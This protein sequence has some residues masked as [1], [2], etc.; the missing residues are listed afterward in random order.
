MLADALCVVGKENRLRVGKRRP[1][2]K[3]KQSAAAAHEAVAEEAEAE[4]Q[5]AEADAEE[6]EEV[7][8]GA[9]EE[10]TQELS[11]AD[12]DT[13]AQ[14]TATSQ[15]ARTAD[16]VHD[17]AGAGCGGVHRTGFHAVSAD[18]TEQG[19]LELLT[20][21]TA[22]FERHTPASVRRE[23]SDPKKYATNPEGLQVPGPR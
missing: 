23:E 20:R 7:G 21:L 12:D 2:R 13:A 16:E 4:A 22:L 6:A 10:L 5:E 18:P 19:D 17:E 14:K 11:A 9:A 8:E 15:V 3:K 1:A